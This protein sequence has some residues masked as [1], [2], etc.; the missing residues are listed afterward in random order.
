VVT[1]I[2]IANVGECTWQALQET[3][4]FS[5]AKNTRK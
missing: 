4:K 2:Y 3:P 5:W 1:F